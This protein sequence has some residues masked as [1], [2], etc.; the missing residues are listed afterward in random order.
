MTAAIIECIPQRE[1]G[2]RVE[3][4]DVIYN[5]APAE[6]Y[7]PHVAVV[8]DPDAIARFMEIP[9]FRFV[10]TVAGDAEPGNLGLQDNPAQ[11]GIKGAAPDQPAPPAAAPVVPAQTPDPASDAPITAET[12]ETLTD[13]ELDAKHVE[14]VGAKP[15]GRAKR[16]TII[17][18]ILEAV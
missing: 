4:F 5:F 2:S 13:D 10:G 8:A 17:A 1:G 15:H 12:L 11:S 18:S 7:G 16:T 9:D 3:L 14:V 6:P